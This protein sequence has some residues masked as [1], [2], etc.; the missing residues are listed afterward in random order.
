MPLAVAHGD[1][2]P[3]EVDLGPDEGVDGLPLV[4]GAGPLARAQALRAI[5]SRLAATADVMSL[6]SAAVVVRPM[7]GSSA[8]LVPHAMAAAHAR[9]VASAAAADFAWFIMLIFYLQSVRS[10]PTI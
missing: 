8:A 6:T 9:T 4:S 2:P 10:V 7:A 3:L 5:A 1:L